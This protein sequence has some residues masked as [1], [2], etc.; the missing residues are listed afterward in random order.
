M[1]TIAL[2][3]LVGNDEARLLE[4]LRHGYAAIMNMLPDGVGIVP[5]G[6]TVPQRRGAAMTPEMVEHMRAF[7]RQI[8]EHVEH[9][10]AVVLLGEGVL[11]ASHSEQA[12]FGILNSME[13]ASEIRLMMMAAGDR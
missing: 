12:V 1:K 5:W 9:Q 4:E 11:C 7:I 3:S 8:R 13:R 2:S 6:M 10:E